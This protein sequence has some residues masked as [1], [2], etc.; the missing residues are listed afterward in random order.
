[1]PY[2]EPFLDPSAMSG[3]SPYMSFGL[4]ELFAESSVDTLHK[5]AQSLEQ[6]VARDMDVSRSPSVDPAATLEPKVLEARGLETHNVRTQLEEQKIAQTEKT[7]EKGATALEGVPSSPVSDVQTVASEEVPIVAEPDGTTVQ[8]FEVPDEYVELMKEFTPGL[9][10]PSRASREELSTLRNKYITLVDKMAAEL[11][12]E[13]VPAMSA[14]I[15]GLGQVLNAENS[16]EQ[17]QTVLIALGEVRNSDTLTPEEKLADM[18]QRFH[19]V[20][21]RAKVQTHALELMQ[22]GSPAQR[23]VAVRILSGGI[24]IVGMDALDL[25]NDLVE[26]MAHTLRDIEDDYRLS[27]E[28]LKD[29]ARLALR[30]Q[31]DAGAILKAILSAP[32]WAFDDD[33]LS[34]LVSALAQGVQDSLDKPELLE[35]GPVQAAAPNAPG[36]PADPSGPEVPDAPAGPA[37]LSGVM[38]RLAYVD[39]LFQGS[40]PESADAALA[41]KE[42][43]LPGRRNEARIQHTMMLAS[44]QLFT[45]VL[46]PKMSGKIRKGA[47]ARAASGSVSMRSFLLRPENV[48]GILA[49]AGIENFDFHVAHVA[50]LQKRCWECGLLTL[51]QQETAAMLDMENWCLE[52]GLSAE[53][54]RYAG[55]LDLEM[56]K[57]GAEADEHTRILLG[58]C[59]EFVRGLKGSTQRNAAG[60]LVM[61]VAKLTGSTLAHRHERQLYESTSDYLARLALDKQVVSLSGLLE[62]NQRFREGLELNGDAVDEAIRT[63]NTRFLTELADGSA[64]GGII[65]GGR[66]EADLRQLAEE[67]VETRRELLLE[68]SKFNTRQQQVTAFAAALN[69]KL[70]VRRARAELAEEKAHMKAD[71]SKVRFSWLHQRPDRHRVCTTVQDVARLAADLEAAD[72]EADRAIIQ[73]DLDRALEEL[74]G[75]DPFSMVHKSKFRDVTPSLDVVLEHMLPRARA[76]EYFRLHRHNGIP[77]SEASLSALKMKGL[78]LKAA[79][80]KMAVNAHTL[81]YFKSIGL[82]NM[83]R[84]RDTAMAAVLRVYVESGQDMATFS[85]RNAETQQRLA[86]QLA[87]WGLNLEL[88]IMRAVVMTAV[89]KLTKG[90]GRL[91]ENV[92]RDMADDKVRYAGK[93]AVDAMK[94]GLRNEGRSALGAWKQVRSFLKHDMLSDETKRE[95]GI[96]SLMNM[97]SL[98]GGGFV[99]DRT[100]GVVMDTG[101]VFTPFSRPSSLV[102]ITSLHSPLSMKFQMMTSNS[103]TVLN[104]GKG[105]YQVMLK[106]KDVTELSAKLKIPIGQYIGTVEAGGSGS[107]ECGLAFTFP[108]KESC[109]AFLK[110]FMRKESDLHSSQSAAS[111]SWRSAVDVRFLNGRGGSG[112]MTLGLMKTMLGRKVGEETSISLSGVTSLNFSGGV[113]VDSESSAHGETVTLSR[114]GSITFSRVLSGGVTHGEA[115]FGSPLANKGIGF[116]IDLDQR[117]KVVTNEKGLAD[118]TCVETEFGRGTLSVRG[119]R[120]ALLPSDLLE[121]IKKDVT[122][123]DAL[124]DVLNGLPRTARLVVHRKIKPAVLTRARQLMVD[125]RLASTEEQSKA[126]LDA[127]HRL[128]ARFDSYTPDKLIVKNAGPQKLGQGWSPGFA[129]LQMSRRG[130]VT[131]LN[132][133]PALEIRLPEPAREVQEEQQR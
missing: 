121:A 36:D 99:Y 39:M 76:L 88:P 46:D 84:L 12:P 28:A 74:R 41:L 47:L 51:S 107:S 128:L 25:E 19:A 38:E 45:D 66:S 72:N 40:Y 49:S 18:S 120:H 8:I 13:L 117:F 113:N 115:L 91:D 2:T 9:M 5:V 53:A 109:E 1:M 37:R 126:K 92:L 110:D 80:Q 68:A 44:R 97:A 4:E 133:S 21:A 77:I 108:S 57:G 89:S 62:E 100:N 116:K 27:D 22:A 32:Q 63:A 23:D 24:G 112:N 33:H 15:G 87:R 3:V 106:G 86:E 90:T 114:K 54:A 95:A 6:P 96:R 79:K 26:A 56:Q 131:S 42:L 60:Q 125:A 103:I 119:L 78:A 130:T 123:S 83:H 17:L 102:T 105:A 94:Q 48:P 59:S 55:E 93:D 65:V 58:A 64:L 122:F 52:L 69:E 127:A 70:E 31:F 81:R 75:V 104:K 61:D 30:G 129:M 82:K 50:L 14:A 132:S 43:L 124:D 85:V 118:T 10:L 11:R 7:E 71:K 101:S 111:D 67:R 20:W 35:R 29:L 34:A 98:P 16:R 73:A